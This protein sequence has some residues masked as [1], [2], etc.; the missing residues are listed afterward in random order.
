MEFRH[1]NIAEMHLFVYE[2]YKAKH[3]QE[4]FFNV[5]QYMYI[6][7]LFCWQFIKESCW[8][9]MFPVSCWQIKN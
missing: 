4:F 1:Y 9:I 2:I 5:M 6:K 7:V 3:K 8:Q